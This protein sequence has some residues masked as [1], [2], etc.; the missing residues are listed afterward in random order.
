MPDFY[1]TG[2]RGTYGSWT[3]MAEDHSQDMDV[4]GRQEL[5]WVVPR[6]LEPGQS[7]QADG[8]ASSKA[9]THRIDWRTPTGEAYALQGDA[10]HNGEA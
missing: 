5:G 6:V 7:T 2:S 4:F 9:D 3:L 1:S 8:F 10:V